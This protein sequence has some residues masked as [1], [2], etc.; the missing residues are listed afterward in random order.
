MSSEKIIIKAET[1]ETSKAALRDL[2]NTQ[3]VPG[4]VYRKGGNMNIAIAAANLPKGHTWTRS[5]SVEVDGKTINAIMREVQVDAL[6]N[7]PRHI[8]FQEVAPSDVISATFPVEFVGLTKEQEKEGSLRPL[9]RTITLKGAVS[10]FPEKIVVDVS[11]LA[12]DGTLHLEEAQLPQGLRFR[13][14]L[15]RPAVAQLI[16]K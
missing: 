13:A 11:Q 7:K 2:R 3:K 8:D 9:M 4:V 15:R 5:V 10:A 1:R 12:L 14:G 6:T 16:R